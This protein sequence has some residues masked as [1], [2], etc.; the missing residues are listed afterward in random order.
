LF[1]VNTASGGSSFLLSLAPVVW[2]VINVYVWVVVIRV[3][4]SW[5]SP[6]E[7][8]P[9]MAFLRKAVDPAV[10]FT[11]GVWPLRLGGLDFS[12]VLLILAL[13]FLANFLRA[14]LTH[15]GKG[16]G[17][18]DLGPIFI[19]CFLGLVTSLAWFIWFVMVVR[20]IMSLVRPSAYN[21][22]VMMVY[23]VT[24]PLLAP[25][26][27]VFRPGPGGLDTR[28]LAAVV[29]I[30]VFNQ[31]ILLRLMKTVQSWYASSVVGGLGF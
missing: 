18:S 7:R 13:H 30:F 12:P 2:W 19:F 27:N 1:P 11:R 20:V 8:A 31:Y 10:R 16:F 17:A 22:V 6:D 21:P 15:L 29:G 9:F 14:G 5:F 23:A 24:E 3:L 4:L 26:R 25:L 28:A